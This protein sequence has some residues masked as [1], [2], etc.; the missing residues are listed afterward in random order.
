M[1]QLLDSIE[2]E[3]ELGGW[4]IEWHACDLFPRGWIDLVIVLRTNSTFLYDRLKSRQYPEV[5]LQQNID[6]EIMEVILSEARESY[7]AEIVVELQ[8]NEAEDIDSNVKRIEKWIDGW[9]HVRHGDAT[10]IAMT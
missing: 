9:N 6:S 3:V 10:T 7:D 8:S 1:T 2:D 4:I 5:K